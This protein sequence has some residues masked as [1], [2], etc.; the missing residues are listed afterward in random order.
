M[1]YSRFGS[2]LTLISKDQDRDGQRSV[3][4]TCEGMEGVRTYLR[5]EMTADEGNPEI[6]A[7]VAKLPPTPPT[8]GKK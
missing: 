6:D 4:A 2:K 1:I 5:R 8:P 7:A 3:Q